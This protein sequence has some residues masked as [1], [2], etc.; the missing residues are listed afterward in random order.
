M[1]GTDWRSLHKEGEYLGFCAADGGGPG[2][3]EDATDRL[4][5]D[6]YF[7]PPIWPNHDG[8]PSRCV[9]CQ[10][11]AHVHPYHR[12]YRGSGPVWQGP[13]QGVSVQEDQDCI[14]TV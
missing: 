4:L 2:G 6:A 14:M 1:G 13:V 9:P 5:T 3:G 8:D 12:L 10:V 7:H 11:T